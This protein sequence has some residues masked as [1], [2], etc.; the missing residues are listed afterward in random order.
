M[1]KINNGTVTNLTL[2]IMLKL[3]N[4]HVKTIYVSPPHPP[5]PPHPPPPPPP[6]PSPPTPPTHPPTPTHTHT[7]TTQG[8]W[9]PSSHKTRTLPFYT[10]NIMGADVLATRE[11]GHQRPWYLQ[12]W[13]KSNGPCT[14]KSY[15]G[16]GE[17]GMS[18]VSTV[19]LIIIW[20]KMTQFT[21]NLVFIVWC[22]FSEIIQFWATL[23]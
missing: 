10:V 1:W 14:L 15:P 13:T 7:D 22:Q 4:V 21:S 5:T 12:R 2:Y 20:K 18:N 17:V 16:M 23:A 8:Q 9:N 6:P 19:F 11:P 3:K